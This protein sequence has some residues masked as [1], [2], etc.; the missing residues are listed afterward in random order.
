MKL[1]GLDTETTNKEPGCRPVE[2]AAVEVGPGTVTALLDRVCN[3]GIPIPAQSSTIHGLLEADR[4]ACLSLRDAI[5]ELIG[6]LPTPAGCMLVMHNA[7]FDCGTLAWSAARLGIV[8]P[9]WPVLCTLEL[10]RSVRGQKGGNSLDRLCDEFGLVRPGGAHRAFG[11]AW[12]ALEVLPR[13]G[14]DRECI[15]FASPFS[16]WVEKWDGAYTATMPEGFEFLPELCEA[17]GSLT[18]DYVNAK[19]AASSR[20]IHPQGWALRGGNFHFHGFC[21]QAQDTRAFR[22]DRVVAVLGCSM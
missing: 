6:V 15:P 19:G 10:A 11:D 13:L 3:P 8:L 9:D 1:I 21:D 12:A 4:L 22:A 18:F 16:H 7:P 17:G 20:T 5:E 2:I 14:V